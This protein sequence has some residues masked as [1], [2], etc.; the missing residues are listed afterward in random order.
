MH[1]LLI[2]FPCYCFDFRTP[3]NPLNFCRSTSVGPSFAVL[4]YQRPY[5]SLGV[6]TPTAA[7]YFA[8]LLG[9]RLAGSGLGSCS[10]RFGVSLSLRLAWEAISPGFL[11]TTITR[12][13][14]EVK[15]IYTQLSSLLGIGRPWQSLTD[16]IYYAQASCS[17]QGGYINGSLNDRAGGKEA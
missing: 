10:Y 15:G 16:I 17:E 14:H 3:T 8:F 9:R 12:M 5:L 13:R 6:M 2:R 7:Q 4:F 11:H 1:P